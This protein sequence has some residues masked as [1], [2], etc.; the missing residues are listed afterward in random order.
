MIV[1]DRQDELREY[2]TR[3]TK[4]YYDPAM[5][6]CIG[7]ETNGKIVAVTAFNNYNGASTQIHIAITGRLTREYTL[8]VY[9]YAFDVMKVHKLIGLVSSAN[10]KALRFDKH[11]GYVEEARI[12]DGYPDGDVII[13]T[14]T[15]DQCK[16][17]QKDFHKT[18]II[19]HKQ[20]TLFNVYQQ[21]H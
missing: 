18:D 2:I 12:K 13:L 6:T 10:E 19:T 14:M 15:R 17:L 1:I 16:F 7:L 4:G 20:A 8:Y 5:T 11:S 3:K 9:R 21:R